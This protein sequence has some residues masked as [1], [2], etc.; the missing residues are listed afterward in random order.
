MQ[1]TD[2]KLM[3][4]YQTGDAQAFETLYSRNAPKIYS[5]LCARL[6]RKE[7]VDECFQMVFS[8]FHRMRHRY[9][10]TYSVE[11]WLYVISKSTLIDHFRKEARGV[12]ISSKNSIE[13][14][15][16]PSEES[17]ILEEQPDLPLDALTPQQKQ[18]VQWR[19]MDE[20]SYE[21][22][23]KRL[24]ESE[25]NIRQIF[26]RAVKKLRSLVTQQGGQI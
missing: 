26:S 5:Y 21:E 3:K 13:E 7:L 8:K 25:T 1:L 16:I 20:F 12:P 24:N 2:E 10:S 22:I 4:A 15:D 23:A 18:V 17:L 19:I 6:K 11:Q 9:D 14:L